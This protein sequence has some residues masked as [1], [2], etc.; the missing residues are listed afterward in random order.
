VYYGLVYYRCSAPILRLSS[1]LSENEDSHPLEIFRDSIS[2]SFCD[3]ACFQ[4]RK[5]EFVSRC[6]RLLSSCFA[7]S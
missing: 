2:C 7:D 4:P 1:R 6:Q 5:F 3:H